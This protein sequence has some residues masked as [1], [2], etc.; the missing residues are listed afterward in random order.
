MVKIVI[1]ANILV[2][3]IFGGI[4]CQAVI[5]A[6]EYNIYYSEKIKLELKKLPEKLINK[7]SVMQNIEFKKLVNKLLLK[8]ENIKIKSKVSI[9]RDKKDNHY[10]ETA[11]AVKADFLITGDKDLLQIRP[12]KLKNI[13][14]NK[15][16]IISPREFIKLS[17]S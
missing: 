1:D 17:V 14:L 16:T 15:L 7:L 10:L 6:F 11:L 8:G 13:G 3:A 2:S 5:K 9:C 4:P 12:S